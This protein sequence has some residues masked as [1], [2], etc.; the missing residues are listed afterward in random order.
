MPIPIGCRLVG[1]EIVDGCKE[2]GNDFLHPDKCIYLCGA[3]DGGIPKSIL[4]TCNDIVKI[5]GASYC[6]NVASAGSI[7]MYDRI[8]QFSKKLVNPQQRTT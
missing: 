7:V 3:E 5:P 6:L 4:G 8:R 2:L 1:V